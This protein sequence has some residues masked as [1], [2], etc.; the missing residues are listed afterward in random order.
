MVN[1]SLLRPVGP[2]PQASV[3]VRG[4]EYS[5]TRARLGGFVRLQ[6]ARQAMVEAAKAQDTGGLADAVFTCLYHGIGIDRAEFESAGWLELVSA[7][8]VVTTVNALPEAQTLAIMKYGQGGPSVPWDYQSR[9]LVVWLHTF[10]RA[11]GWT[12]D[13]TFDVWPEEAV[14]LLQEIQAD[15]FSEKEFLHALSE[16]AYAVGQDGKASYRPMSKPRWMTVNPKAAAM[17]IPRSTLPVGAVIYPKDAPKAYQNLG[18]DNK[19][20]NGDGTGDS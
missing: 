1:G 4:R 20:K 9:P 5:V 6:L 11:Y 19:R 10:A 12:G 2:E 16:V 17:K 14:A 15:D 18:P 13:Q 3:T 7:L 8:V